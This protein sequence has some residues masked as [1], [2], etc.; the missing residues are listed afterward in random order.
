MSALVSVAK[1][2]FKYQ[3]ICVY[4]EILVSDDVCWQVL[5]GN[6]TVSEMCRCSAI[7]PAATMTTSEPT[8]NIS[9]NAPAPNGKK[10]SQY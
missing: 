10:P 7:L 9:N 3:Y 8:E 1:L 5:Y 6:G 2:F 4:V